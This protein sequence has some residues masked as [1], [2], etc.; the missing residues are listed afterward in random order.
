[1]HQ[2][3]L[4]P[5]VIMVAVGMAPLAL[6]V[7]EP[8]PLFQDHAVLQS[9]KPIPVWGR[10]VPGEHVTVSFAGQAVG[11]TAGPDGRWIAVLAPLA[12]N[13][14]G[15]D[16]AIAGTTTVT[17]HDILVGEVWLCSGQSNMLF[18]VDSGEPGHSVTNAAAEVA[19]A[20]YP[21]IRH[22]KVAGRASAAP[23]D[24]AKGAWTVC[25]PQTVGHFTAVGYF[26]ARDL[27]KRL[28]VPIGIINSTWGGTPVESWM[29]PVAL[30][31]FPGLFIG[32][33]TEGATPDPEDPMAPGSLFNGMIHPLLPYAIRGVIWYQ[34]EG[35]VRHVADYDVHFK[36]MITAWRSHFGQGDFPFFWVQLANFTSPTEPP[37][38]LWAFIREAQSR[39]LSLPAT[40]QAVAIDIGEANNVHPRNKQEVGRRLALIAK[41]K[42]YSIPV[43]CSGPVLDRIEKEGSSIRVRFSFAGEGLTASDKPLQSFE[44]A[45]DDRVFHPA[46]AVIRGGSI[47]VQSAAV[48]RP[49]AVRYAWRN[50]PEANLYNGAGLPAAPFRSD[51]W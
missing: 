36:A 42:V 14:S 11:A 31:A 27:F 43:D 3:R 48:K 35:N 49:V 28:N 50:A 25:S 30:S 1:M 22:F 38:E 46:S 32:R 41:A 51:D 12:A 34:G 7:P 4:L 5:H 2:I 40:G 47:L 17:L 24:I 29:S 20:R 45:G 44:V 23:V 26:F 33:P 16:L 18:M 37:G 19:A 8:A 10:A 21:L 6:A 39:A 15:V 9:D 13:S